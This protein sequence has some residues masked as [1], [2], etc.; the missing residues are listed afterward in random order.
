MR[1]A[2]TTTNTITINIIY[3]PR[4]S[5]DD[6]MME[7]TAIVVFQIISSMPG[8]QFVVD[9]G[10]GTPGQVAGMY[11]HQSTGDEEPRLLLH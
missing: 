10:V 4:T 8:R 1:E 11:P 6:H 2:T 9:W 5:C 7:T 3:N